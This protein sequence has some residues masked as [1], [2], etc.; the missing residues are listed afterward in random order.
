MG[1]RENLCSGVWFSGPSYAD[2]ESI[3]AVTVVIIVVHSIQT[4]VEDIVSR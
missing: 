3:R 4:G 1:R 2:R